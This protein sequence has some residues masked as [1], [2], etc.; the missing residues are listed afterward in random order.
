MALHESALEELGLA[1]LWVRRGSANAPAAPA[2]AARGE[3]A[4][5]A[6]AQDVVPATQARVNV[7]ADAARFE[8]A[9]DAATAARSDAAGFGASVA[10]GA[11]A[12]RSGVPSSDAAEA[13]AAA[14]RSASPAERNVPRETASQSAPPETG[15][16]PGTAR[17]EPPPAAAQP[18]APDDDFAWFDDLAAQPSS[19]AR[20]STSGD[21]AG[22]APDDLAPEPS[23][24]PVASLDWDALVERVAGCERCRLCEKRTQTVF[25]VGDRHADWMLIGEAPGENED[26]Q[27]EPF[28]G[29]AGKL[30]DNMLRSLSLARGANVYIANVLKCRPPGNRN[31]EPEEVARCEPYLQRQV[32]LVK[33][34]LIVALGRFAAQSLLKTD[35]S[36]SSLRGRVHAYEGVPVIVTYHPAYL[37]RSLHDK[38]KA[39]QDLCLARETW[40]KAGASAGSADDAA[41]D[42]AT[43]SST[44]SATGSATDR[45]TDPAADPA[46]DPATDPATDPAAGSSTDPAA[47]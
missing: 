47:N 12:R 41:V 8:R 28:V 15:R 23:L 5:V 43:G 30:L 46:A 24:P 17:S 31:P 6:L 27:G 25:G 3:T 32:A 18:T 35:A 39:W 38:G 40:R 34:K 2:D 26:R 44:G 33:P 42:P 13:T 9:P 1:P 19:H 29:Q 37:L 21:G 10:A 11:E 22:F 16:R 45:A 14:T 36:I 4:D 20:P 7:S